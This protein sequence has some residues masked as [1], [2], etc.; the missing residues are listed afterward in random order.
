M[1]VTFARPAE[2]SL[3]ITKYG[4][5]GEP[6]VDLPVNVTTGELSY[7]VIRNAAMSRDELLKKESVKI[8]PQASIFN[9]LVLSKVEKSTVPEPTFGEEHSAMLQALQ[10]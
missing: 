8:N 10:I 7:V 1:W 4:I 2:D 5:P 9:C 3:V 6:P